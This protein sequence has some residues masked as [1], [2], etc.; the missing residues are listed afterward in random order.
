MANDNM[1]IGDSVKVEVE[2][3]PIVETKHVDAKVLAHAMGELLKRTAAKELWAMHGSG[4]YKVVFDVE[5]WREGND[6]VP[7]LLQIDK[8]AASFD[9]PSIDTLMTKQR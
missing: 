3:A 6:V 5:L 4:H 2:R 1:S 8:V 9:M 7:R